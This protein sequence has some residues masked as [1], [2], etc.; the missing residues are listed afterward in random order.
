MHE[1][2]A[3]VEMLERALMRVA[4]Q[5]VAQLRT[6]RRSDRLSRWSPRTRC[7]GAGG[8]LDAHAAAQTDLS[9]IRFAEEAALFE[10]RL[11]GYL[12]VSRMCSGRS[13]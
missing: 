11:A 3:F 12:W 4:Q 2:A 7:G 6:S 13:R 8:W 9:A 1:P 10:R 5:D